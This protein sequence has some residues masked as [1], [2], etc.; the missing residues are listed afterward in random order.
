MSESLTDSVLAWAEAL[1]KEHGAPGPDPS[2]AC[3]P[4]GEDP[5]VHQM[6]Y[7]MLLWE[8][9]HEQAGR[10]L[11]ALR[12]QVVNYNELRVCSADEVGGMLPRDCPRREERCARLLAAMN[13]VFEREHGLSL[14]GVGAMPKR[15]AR[16]YLDQ[17]EGLP[18]FA[19]ARIMLVTLGGH[20]FP[21]DDRLADVL[22]GLDDIEDDAPLTEVIS[23]MER[24][25]RASDSARVYALLEAHA[26]TA[27][28]A[29]RSGGKGG[30]KSSR[31]RKKDSPA[32]EPGKE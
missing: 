5:L 12:G 16:Q 3:V 1:Q 22:R 26:A 19:A 7:S 8:A 23:R 28:K 20:A 14:A 10:W 13:A 6:V 27:P 11:E 15:E 32:P 29:K 21:V 4:A 17:I 9:S 2:L 25:V 30:T 18:P 24:N 31:P